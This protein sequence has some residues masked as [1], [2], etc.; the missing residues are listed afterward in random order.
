MNSAITV[1]VMIP[2]FKRPSCLRRCLQGIAQQLRMPEQILVIVQSVDHET[3]EM[4]AQQDVLPE[5]RLQVVLVHEPGVIQAQNAGLREVSTD[6]VAIID[7]DAV[8]AEDWL[9]RIVELFVDGD[10]LLVAVGGRDILCFERPN[11]DY[12]SDKVGI[13][14]PFGM[15]IGNHHCGIG[16]VRDVLFLKGVNC[17]YRTEALREV[18]GFEE[19]L[20]GRGAQAHWELD[21]GLKLS[22]MGYRLQYDPQLTVLHYADARPEGLERELSQKEFRI[23]ADETHNVTFALCT[24]HSRGRFLWYSIYALLVGNRG[25]YGLAQLLRFLPS[26]RLI[27]VSNFIASM[28]GWFEGVQ[29]SCAAKKSL[30]LV[31]DKSSQSGP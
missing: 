15:P 23:V 31:K 5:D 28:L 8:P 30:P 16:P 21:L 24:H 9:K 25:S 3:I 1:A 14:S 22:R 7:D 27:A 26:L 6:V 18:G 2:T 29:T 10:S 12:R 19:R 20:K 11:S 17:A 4:L 13:F